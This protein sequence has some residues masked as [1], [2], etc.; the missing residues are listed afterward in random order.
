MITE[1]EIGAAIRILAAVGDTIR[2]L[3]RVPAGHLYALLMP[4]LTLQQFEQCVGLLVK[5]DQVVREGDELVWKGG[6]S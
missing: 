3:K 6:A 2:E 5:A 4:K 1:A